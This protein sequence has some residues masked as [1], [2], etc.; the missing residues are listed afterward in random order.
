MNA[1]WRARYRWNLRFRSRED[2]RAVE[3]LVVVVGA[4]AT[5]AGAAVTGRW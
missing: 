4:L 2:R 3:A 5:I 1:M